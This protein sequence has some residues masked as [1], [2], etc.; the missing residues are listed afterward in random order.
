MNAFINFKNIKFIETAYETHI[1]FFVVSRDRIFSKKVF[2][3][4]LIEMVYD[5]CTS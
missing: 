3:F 4:T 5:R 1:K 2:A